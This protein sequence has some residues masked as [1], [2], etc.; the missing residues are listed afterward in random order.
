MGVKGGKGEGRDK[1]GK[2][3]EVGSNTKLSE[4]IPEY[5]CV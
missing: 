5:S 2:D 1:G 4:E 3:L